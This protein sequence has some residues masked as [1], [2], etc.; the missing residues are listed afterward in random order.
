[1]RLLS[2]NFSLLISETCVAA[3]DN[4]VA[5]PKKSKNKNVK[6][7]T[8]ESSEVSNADLLK[9]SNM[10]MREMFTSIQN[11][12][13]YQKAANQIMIE[14]KPEPFRDI[15]QSNNGNIKESNN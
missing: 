2:S 7:T 1:M 14:F 13:G 9:S 6:I 15:N 4:V 11:I 3:A 5:V 10:Q 8:T 12:P